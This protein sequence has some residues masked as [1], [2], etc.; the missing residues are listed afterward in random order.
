MRKK[1][2][3][4]IRIC[5]GCG[6]KRKKEEMLQF[7]KGT[8]EVVFVNGKKRGNGRGFYLCPDLVCFKKAQKKEKRVGSLGS[9]DLLFPLMKGLE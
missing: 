6:R 7:I 9:I 5:I 2:H 1:A 3:V 4:P 8:D